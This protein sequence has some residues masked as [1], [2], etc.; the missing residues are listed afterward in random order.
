MK[1]WIVKKSDDV[2]V[3]NIVEKTDLSKTAAKIL[4][5]RGFNDIES[6]RD[7]FDFRELEDPFELIDM[8]KAADAVNDAVQNGEKI[9]IYGDYDCDGV[10]ATAILYSYLQM[11]GADVICYIP[12]RSEGYGLNKTAI[13]K[14]NNENA[15]LIITVDNGISA[16]DEAE[17][18]AELGMKLVITDHHRPSDT[19][20]RAIAVVDPHRSDCPS[21]FKELAGV[22]VALKLIA[23][24]EGDYTAALEEYSALAA[25]GTVADIVSL[26]GENRIIVTRGIESIKNTENIGLG[27][28]LDKCG[29]SPD[30][31]DSKTISFTLA[32]R[33]NSAGRF[34][35]AI[36]ALNALVSEDEDA[37][38]YVDE[39]ITL[40]S[41][42]KEAEA[43]IYDEILEFIEKNPSVLYERVLVL[44]GEGWHHGVIG[45]V[46]AKLLNIY[47]KPVFLI[48]V[49]PDG[50]AT[51]SV[52]SVDG[53]N[54]FNA[55]AACED[56]LIKYGGHEKAGGFSLKSCNIE[57]FTEL[58]FE[59]ANTEFDEIPPLYLTA[60][61]V[62]RADELTVDNIKSLSVLEP[63]GEGNSEPV[64]LIRGAKVANIYSLGK[65]NHVKISF[66]YDGITGQ[67]V[68]FFKRV[69]E[70]EFSVNDIIDMLVNIS[71]NEYMGKES[72][73]IK[74]I[75]YRLSGLDQNKYLNAK[76]AYER[77]VCR[78]KLS[79]SYLKAMTPTR[80]EF[81]N[82]YKTLRALKKTSFDRLYCKLA[83]YR[84]NFA[85]MLITLDVFDE[86]KLAKVDHAKKT[87]EI[88]KATERVD[89][90][91]S[92]ILNAL[93]APCFQ[94]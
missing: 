18:I 1:Q 20:P 66:T 12:E 8:D 9:C 26:T 51:G 42:R 31:I 93:K 16:F 5:A 73:S 59:Y 56:K 3:Q 77:F 36:T 57:G 25:I 63:F 85:K 74:V 54:V 41:K 80:E 32:P 50:N 43:K 91:N 11:M 44:A 38:E 94:K 61:T 22:G 34:G 68:M 52:R 13:E 69:T 35:S 84:I 81:V 46:A 64:F 6:L 7:F 21:A 40:N 70:L 76:R 28:L 67:A 55:L 48:S 30:K 2:A 75:D 60:D 65:G 72:L 71:V 19:L 83:V 14:I 87:A 45:I 88:L 33:I 17:Y 39:L 53:F 58:L 86:M 90:N 10:T 4:S 82:V 27:A 62:I 24:C 79:D 49:D 78:Q 89:L 23:A 92:K 29:I 15:G 37:L 47:E